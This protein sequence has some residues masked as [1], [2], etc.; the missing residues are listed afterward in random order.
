MGIKGYFMGELEDEQ[1]LKIK[2]KDILVA[3]PW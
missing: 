3:Q 1:T 2:A